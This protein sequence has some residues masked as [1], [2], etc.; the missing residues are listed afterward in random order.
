[1]EAILEIYRNWVVPLLFCML[2]AWVLHHVIGLLKA[3]ALRE[4]AEAL[5][6]H[7]TARARLAEA[8][9]RDDEMRLPRP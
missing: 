9:I 2:M 3:K 4:M 5:Q 1:M 8:G 7:A 6:A